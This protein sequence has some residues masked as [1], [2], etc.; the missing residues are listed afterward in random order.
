MTA[1]Q[2]L[3]SLE[4]GLPSSGPVRGQA[5]NAIRAI[6]TKGLVLNVDGTTNTGNVIFEVL[7]KKGAT[8]SIKDEKGM[9]KGLINFG[10]DPVKALI[11]LLKKMSGSTIVIE[12]AH[13]QEIKVPVFKTDL[14]A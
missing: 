3:K 6:N 12:D 1:I 10:K 4:V 8:A 13:Q 14:L 7:T 11:E 9:L 5:V 2:A